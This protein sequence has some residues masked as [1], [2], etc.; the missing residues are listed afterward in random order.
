MCWLTE[1]FKKTEFPLI[2]TPPLTIPHPEEPANPAITMANF[3]L[4][5][6]FDRWFQGW[7]V[8]VMERDYWRTA[9]S[10]EVTEAIPYPAQTWEQDG[11]RHLDVRPEWLNPGVIAHEQ[12]HNSYTLL[13]QEQ[14]EG[15]ARKH[16]ALKT[17]DPLIKL[18]YSTNTYGLT[19]DIEG[20]AECY[21]FLGLSLPEALK[22]Y[23]PK[24]L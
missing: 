15:F 19:N 12:A 23:Y 9:I 10:V 16:T 17:S 13:S 1:L 2:K 22:P 5:G 14:K 6:V 4:D 11:K 7:N 18:L 21:R 20:H 24:L 8:P 3:N